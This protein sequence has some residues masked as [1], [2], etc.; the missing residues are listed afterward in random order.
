M[1]PDKLMQLADNRYRLLKEREEWDA[2]SQEEEKLLALQ[3]EVEKLKRGS[4]R[5]PESKNDKQEN[6]KSSNKKV[7]K[8]ERREKPGWMW[9]RPSEDD[10]AKPRQWNGSEWWYCHPDTGGKCNR[11]YRRHKPSKCEGR[12]FRKT[13]SPGHTNGKAEVRQHTNKT[14]DNDNR[15]LKV[16]EA[17]NAIINDDDDNNSSSDGYDS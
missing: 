3:A 5:R 10:L 14:N 12:S 16:S 13:K 8:Q 11:V 7:R 4:K 6:Q 1:E 17:L 2:P 15:K 9:E